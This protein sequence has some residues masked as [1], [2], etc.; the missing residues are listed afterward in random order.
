MEVEVKNLPVDTI[1]SD[2]IIVPIFEK[3]IFQEKGLG[4]TC[5]NYINSLL[6]ENKCQ[7]YGQTTFIHT[8]GFCNSK[9]ILLL[10]LGEKEILTPDKVRQTIA[11]AIRTAC[12]QKIQTASILVEDL[13]MESMYISA[14]TEGAILGDYKFNYYKTNNQSVSVEKLFLIVQD[15]SNLN[16]LQ[17]IAAQAVLIANGVNLTRDLV[18]HPAQYMTPEKM[19]WHANEIAQHT[20]MEVSVLQSDDIA[21]AGMHAIKAVAQGSDTLPYFI[22]L[23]YQGNPDSA[24]FIAYIGKGITFDSGGISLKPSEK[25]GDMKG[26]MAGGG[27]VLGAMSV[28][29]QL[30]P[31]VNIWGIIPCAENMPSGHAYRPGD[32]I[33]SLS[34]KTIEIITT[35]AEGRLILA[36]A[37]TYARNHGASKVIDLA[38]LTGACVVALGNSTSGVITNNQD[39]Y[40]SVA[41]AASQTGE[42]IWEM[43]NFT[44]YK[45]L[46]KSDLADL[47]NS[48]GRMAG[49]ITAGLFLGEFAEE[50]PWVHVDIAGT[51]DLDKAQGY[52]HKGATG[53]GV[54][55]LVQLAQ[56][57]GTS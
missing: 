43:P 40:H 21:A 31:K 26:D 35:D 16:L 25:M 5:S 28:I 23:K 2:L 19:A 44:E 37:I 53:A 33:S 6:E 41:K 7:K 36:D 54:R 45:E 29:G 46:I 20:G 30:K 47:K 14:I 1:L 4:D 49:M 57:M 32:I 8:L 50:T 13:L 34:G 39:W 48:G 27:A 52:N 24:E 55:L 3:T 18:N 56:D 10:G 38:T 11:M 9:Q 51:S 42:K 22:V 12:K 15:V 17:S